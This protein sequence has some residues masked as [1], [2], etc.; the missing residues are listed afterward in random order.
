MLEHE[1]QGS[2]TTQS[3]R[4]VETPPTKERWGKRTSQAIVFSTLALVASSLFAIVTFTNIDWVIPA[5]FFG[6][7]AYAA[8]DIF[9]S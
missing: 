2:E 1:D 5:V 8:W 9:F 6:L 4:M 7:L 3:N